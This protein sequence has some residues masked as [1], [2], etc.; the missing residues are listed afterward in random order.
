MDVVVFTVRVEEPV[1]VIEVGLKLPE[2]PV[3]RPVTVGVIVPVNPFNAVVDTLYVVLPPIVTVCELGDTEIEKSGAGALTTSVT[4]TACAR[5][6]PT[7]PVIVN[8]YVPTGVVDVVLMVNADDPPTLTD[9]G[10]KLAEA[11]DGNPLETAK[12]T[13]PVPPS[14]EL[15]ETVK[16]AFC[17]VVVVC[18]PGDAERM[19]PGKLTG[20]NM[21]VP[22]TLS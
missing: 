22:Y 11:P 21:N 6:E 9:A 7:V 19:K 3:G 14:S 5:F 16:L 15:V 1:P 12:F 17:P 2:A 4:C 20:T 18:D 8:V 13:V 10:L